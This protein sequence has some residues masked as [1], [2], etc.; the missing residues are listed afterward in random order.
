MY[1]Y[2]S[3]ISN[4]WTFFD[5]D[6]LNELNKIYLNELTKVRYDKFLISYNKIKSVNG[7][8]ENQVKE[9]FIDLYKSYNFFSEIIQY[10]NNNKAILSY[11]SLTS[12]LKLNK[13]I[14]TINSN[15][16]FITINTYFRFIHL[17]MGRLILFILTIIVFFYI[18]YFL[19]KI[20]FTY[21]KRTLEK[22]HNEIDDNILDNLNKIRRPVSFITI[23][24]GL[25]L[26]FE[27]LIYPNILNEQLLNLF[28]FILMTLI[29]Y[30]I[31]IAIDIFLFSYLVQIEKRNKVIKK[32][33]IKVMITITK[34][35]IFI[36]V[37]LLFL[38][39]INIDISAILTSLGI[40]GL[41]VALAA[42]ATLSN[43]F[44]LIKMIFDDSFSQGDWIETKD[45]EGHVIDISLISTTIRTFDNALI[46]I[47]NSTLANSSIKNWSKR[48]VGRRIKMHIG[49]TYSSSMENL[50]NAIKQIEQM[51]R[52]HKDISTKNK[53]NYNLIN[54]NYKKEQKFVSINDKYGIKSNLLVYLDQLSESSMDILIYAFTKTTSWQEWLEIK[55]DV[56]FQIWK[57]LEDNELEFAFPSQS[58]YIEDN[59]N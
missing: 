22:N 16:I 59:K 46:T 52:E 50:Q 23:V 58:I 38:V 8:I 12:F 47:P 25:K 9:N 49:V 33:I 44:G 19:Y 30:I 27:I 53:I 39:K 2:F 13:I 26:A 11:K 24:I 40:G 35:T 48:K 56:I 3:Y 28:Y 5:K 6:K 42:Q 7:D 21:L 34:I 51:L 18:N 31:F 45:I 15:T 29:T 10:I 41:A 14:E 43:F 17:D 55:Q 20:I 1:K 54:K 37:F 32:E 4:N 36:V 57:I